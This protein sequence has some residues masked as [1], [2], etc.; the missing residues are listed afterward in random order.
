MT[1]WIG[2]FVPGLA[3]I[4]YGLWTILSSSLYYH[5][6]PNHEDRRHRRRLHARKSIPLPPW[7]GIST[8]C[9]FIPF[10]PLGKIILPL[11]GILSEMI[12]AKFSF[13]TPRGLVNTSNFGHTAMY[14]PFVISGVVDLVACRASLP[15]GTERAFVGLAFAI[16]TLTF[17][18]HLHGRPELDAQ[19]H[20][21]LC[22][23]IGASLVFACLEFHDP[24]CFVHRIGRGLFSLIQ[25]TW[26]IQVGFILFG[27][28]P[29]N[30]DEAGVVELI[31]V[32]FCWHI[33]GNL[34]A[35]CMIYLMTWLV[36]AKC[37][38]KSVCGISAWGG[39]SGVSRCDGVCS[40][41]MHSLDDEDEQDEVTVTM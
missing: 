12:T 5:Q 1:T 17:V 23:G 40:L 6:N 35:T 7:Y 31:P 26:F 41:E 30:P 9:C 36:I 13:Y 28:P 37:K 2:H 16:E 27:W 11:P 32:L 38:A 21:M 39:K 33:V 20:I 29:W 8:R 15:V 24:S 18:F 10:E 14:T 19:V 34:L 3:M 4:I 22:V 25:G